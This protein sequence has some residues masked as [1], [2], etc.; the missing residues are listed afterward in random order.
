[1]DLNGY[2]VVK[3]LDDEALR[4]RY[5]EN[6]QKIISRMVRKVNQKR[7]ESMKN[8]QKVENICLFCFR[9]NSESST[10]SSNKTRNRCQKNIFAF[11]AW[12]F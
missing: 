10:S 12:K 5:F 11:R 7:N 3:L 8:A 4:P 2:Q 9:W 6:T 1:M